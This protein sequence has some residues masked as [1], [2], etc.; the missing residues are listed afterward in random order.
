MSSTDSLEIIRHYVEAFIC[1]HFALPETIK[2]HT[3]SFVLREWQ[4][5]IP[6][7]EYSIPEEGR[8]EIT[9]PDEG[10]KTEICN[11]GKLFYK[12]NYLLKTLFFL[13]L[14]KKK[15]KKNLKLYNS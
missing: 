2:I 4:P 1:L 13:S 15:K 6:L 11:I 9:C 8:K 3:K 5:L 10:L 14:L 12:K 7:P